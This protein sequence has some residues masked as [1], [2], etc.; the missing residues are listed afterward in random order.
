MKQVPIGI[1]GC[2]AISQI[3]HIPA[4]LRAKC[5]QL[6]AL[7]DQ[8]GT[9][10]QRVADKAGITTR[11][12][13]YDHMLSNPDIA[14]VVVAVPDP[15]HVSLAMQAL[16]AGKHV[17][18]EKPLGATSDECVELIRLVES[19]GLKLQVGCMKRHDPGIR[20]AIENI[21]TK[22]GRI[23]SFS[24]VFQDTI[25]RTA[26]QATCFDPLIL[27]RPIVATQQEWKTDRRRY[28]LF[29]QGA[30]LFDMLHALAGPMS[31]VRTIEAE[32]SG[33]HS[34]H[35]LLEGISGAT[36]HFELTCKRC[37]DW[38]EQYNVA[39]ENGHIEIDV[40]LWF[41]H[42]PAQVR[43]FIGDQQV[44]TQPL[45]GHSN[46]FAN[47]L[48]AFAESIQVNRPA[49]PDVRDGFAVMK[50]LEAV[51]ISARSGKRVEIRDV[52]WS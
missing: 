16:R 32:V 36:G 48:D 30:H 8:D 52:V 23:L 6:A 39:G 12:T 26:M 34:W 49:S 11:Y 42:R 10:L 44:W 21:R 9:L 13:N 5:V 4:A 28:N 31:A 19:T 51:E 35:G 40:G 1:L 27:G 50:L 2:G 25:F 22:L 3:A 43:T 29:T 17:L 20:H 47:Q 46:M 14:A 18:V 41:Y 7:C 33:N 24:A 45:T 15:L 38:N 37:G